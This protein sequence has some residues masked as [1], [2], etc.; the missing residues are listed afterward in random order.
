[1]GRHRAQPL[2]PEQHGRAQKQ[3]APRTYGQESGTERIRVAVREEPKHPR[4]PRLKRTKL[5][6]REEYQYKRTNWCMYIYKSEEEEGNRGLSV[7]KVLVNA[8][9]SCNLY[10]WNKRSAW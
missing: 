8:N 7:T 6:R 10:R 3:A 2:H 1:M 5:K 4:K 9:R